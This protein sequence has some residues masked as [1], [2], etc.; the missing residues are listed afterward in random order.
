METG[1]L[2]HILRDWVSLDVCRQTRILINED[3]MKDRRMRMRLK[4]ITFGRPIRHY[5]LAT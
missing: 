3:G 2:I 5:S 1:F 4:S